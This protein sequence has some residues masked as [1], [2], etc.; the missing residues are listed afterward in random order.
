[1][2]RWTTC[3]AMG[4]GADAEFL[5]NVSLDARTEMRAGAHSTGNLAHGHHFAGALQPF[6]GAAKFIIHQRKLE[7]ERRRLG[8]DAV[9]AADAGRE[10]V[11]IGAAL[12]DGQQFFHV[13]DENVRRLLHLH[14]VAGVTDVAAGEA[15]V[16][17]AAG[18]VVDGFGDGG[19]EGDDVVVQCFFQ[20]ALPCNQTGQV[21]KPFVAASLDFFK[22]SGGNHFFPHQSL[23]GK[24]FN[25]QPEA[26]LVFIGPNGPHFRPGV[27]RNHETRVRCRRPGVEPVSLRKESSDGKWERNWVTERGVYAASMSIVE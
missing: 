22:I 10:L 19:G 21:G 14:G 9:A 18:V 16:E 7:T 12:D 24:K 17:P 23:A 26:E 3:V 15:E 4:A 5:A 6:Q 27:T 11:F 13:G 2:S 20:L 1:M 8:M 25:L